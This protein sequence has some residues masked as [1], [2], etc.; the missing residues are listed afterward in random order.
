MVTAF[1]I[2]LMPLVIVL[3]GFFFLIAFISALVE[4]FWHQGIK[5]RR[6]NPYTHEYEEVDE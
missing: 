3:A 4:D 5:G 6:Y 1:T 2:L